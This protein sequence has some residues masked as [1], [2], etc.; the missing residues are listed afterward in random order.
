[1]IIKPGVVVHTCNPSAREAKA[2][3]EDH[4]FRANLGYIVRPCLKKI[5]LA[6]NSRI[7]KC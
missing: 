7:M 5:I 6:Q 3:E 4:K 2:G 1:M